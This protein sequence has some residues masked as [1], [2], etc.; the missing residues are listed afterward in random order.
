MRF[1]AFGYK[2]LGLVAAGLAVVALGGLLLASYLIPADAVRDAIKAEIRE[3]TGFETII[4]GPI[5]VSLFPSSSIT[6][7]AVQL[8]GD[9]Q[10]PALYSERLIARLRLIPLIM[11]RI[12]AADIT[13]VEPR[14][15]LVTDARGNSNWSSLADKLAT[16]LKPRAAGGQ[17]VVSFSEIRITKGTLVVRDDAQGLLETLSDIDGALAWPAISKTFGATARFLWRLETFEASLTLNDLLA[18][19]LGERSGVK[20]RLAG[21][22]FKFAFDGALSHKPAMKLEGAVAADGPSLREALA[23]AGRPALPGTSGFGPFA[24]KAQT[25]LVGH[26]V[27]LSPMNVELDG[28]SAEGVLAFALERRPRV[29][30]TLAAE[31]IDFTPYTSAAQALRS[32]EKDWSRVP[33]DLEA[34]D[35]LD[36]DVRLSAGRVLIGNARLGRTAAAATLQGGRLTLTVGESLAFGGVL[37]GAVGVARTAN[38]AEL[39][40]ELQFAN[41]D[42]ESS[43]T[44]LFGIRRLEGKGS[45]ALALSATGE[46]M[47]TL[48]RNLNGS[49]SLAAEKGAMN[50]LNVEQLLRRLERRPLSGGGDFRSGRTPYEKLTIKLK[51]VQGTA[52]VEDV[53]LEGPAVRLAI[54]G[55]ANIPARDLD[56]KGVA[57]LTSSASGTGFELPFVVQGPWDDPIMLPDPQILIRRSG[58]A[59]PLLDAVRDRNTRDAV[60]SAIEQLARP[61]DAGAAPVARP[62]VR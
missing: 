43:F 35:G 7:G 18:A 5:S 62:N 41:V 54:N 40:S 25:N 56:L 46:S 26:Q 21:K 53:N 20:L 52:A 34:L 10:D 15:D 13:L 45:L 16:A 49:V 33:L 24:L 22:P 27:S 3:A 32:R 12:E 44:E 2:R 61:P 58:A 55:S 14:L 29:Q 38:G 37:K 42:V 30:G 50:G 51:I 6:F 8:R 17:R 19:L 9:G 31:T 1:H 39:K 23:W 59:A 57:S 11:G 60:R 4:A 48:T 47:M 28:N 36:L